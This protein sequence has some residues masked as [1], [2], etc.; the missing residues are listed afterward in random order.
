MSD[1]GV[2]QCKHLLSQQ[3]HNAVSSVMIGRAVGKNKAWNYCVS[4]HIPWSEPL[5]QPSSS[6]ACGRSHSTPAKVLWLGSAKV[7]WSGIVET[8]LEAAM[9]GRE[10]L[11]IC[12]WDQ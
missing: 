4:H 2:Q 9:S 7:L 11:Q 10:G 12:C 6:P 5:P 8:A 3:A 1:G